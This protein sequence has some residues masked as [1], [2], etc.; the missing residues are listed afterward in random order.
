[1]PLQ[2][3]RYRFSPS[4]WICR[5]PGALILRDASKRMSPPTTRNLASIGLGIPMPTLAPSS[6][7]TES[8]M[9]LLLV[10]PAT[11]LMV[12]VPSIEKAPNMLRKKR[13]IAIACA[14]DAAKKNANN[15]PTTAPLIAKWRS[16]LRP[17][18]NPK[19]N[20]KY[21]L[22]AHKIFLRRAVILIIATRKP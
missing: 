9:V 18:Y 12:P 11:L 19:R 6:L 20:R 7:I 13:G 15:A 5:R 3:F 10:K 22:A 21:A 8:P 17:E 14:A 1:M 16:L 2:G 4:A